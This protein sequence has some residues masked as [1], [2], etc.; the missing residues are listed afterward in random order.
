VATPGRLFLHYLLFMIVPLGVSTASAILWIHTYFVR[1]RT[2]KYSAPL[3]VA[4]FLWITCILPTAV[5][6]HS[7][8]AW[9]TALFLPAAPLPAAIRQY[10]SPDDQIAVWGWR[11]E[12]YVITRRVPATRFPN[13]GAQEP[14]PYLAHFR[15]L[16]LEDFL[17]AKPRVFVD[18]VGSGNFTFTD[19][20]ASGYE[21]FG[22]LRAV[23]ARDYRQVAEIDSARLF[24]RTGEAR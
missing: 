4:C 21:T 3:G 7:G 6:N 10:A 14:S 22:D 18:G 16:Y 1:A 20:A 23:I 2:W 17:R 9:D 24:V 8:D 5:R 12:L 19:R 11:S 15:R 13:S